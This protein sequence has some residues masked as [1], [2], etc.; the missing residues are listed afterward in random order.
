ML[1][2]GCSERRGRRWRQ[3]GA[4]LLLSPLG[5]LTLL[6]HAVALGDEEG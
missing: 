4:A 2:L 5:L 1:H 3:R 6:V